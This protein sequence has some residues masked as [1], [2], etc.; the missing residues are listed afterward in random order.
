MARTGENSPCCSYK[1]R[2]DAAASV[3][4]RCVVSG[5]KSGAAYLAGPPRLA[6]ETEWPYLVDPRRQTARWRCGRYYY[7]L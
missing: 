1:K 2:K 7:L 5:L 3:H 4:N 6:P